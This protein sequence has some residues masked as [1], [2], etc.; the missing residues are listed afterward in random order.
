MNLHVLCLKF[1]FTF[2]VTK[3]AFVLNKVTVVSSTAC[4]RTSQLQTHGHWT[5]RSQKG[6]GKVVT[7]QI[8]LSSH[9]QV[10]LGFSRY[11]NTQSEQKTL[12]IAA[13]ECI[14]SSTAGNTALK[15]RYCGSALSYVGDIDADAPVC[16]M[17]LAIVG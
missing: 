1:F 2:L 4:V 9:N 16:G 6:S 13:G 17:L 15:S 7:Q 14:R 5:H 3:S 8:T 11:H 12:F 10:G